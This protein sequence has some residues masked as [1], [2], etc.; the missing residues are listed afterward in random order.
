[1]SLV[2]SWLVTCGTKPLMSFATAEE[3]SDHARALWRTNGAK[4]VVSYVVEEIV[5]GELPA[6]VVVRRAA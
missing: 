3:A 4:I 6:D 2:G 1:M 5:S